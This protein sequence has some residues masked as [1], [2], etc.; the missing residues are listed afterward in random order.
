MV[1]SLKGKLIN[2]ST[3]RLSLA[4]RILVANQ[5]LLASM[6]YMVTAWNPNPTMC[7]QIRGIVRNF[8]WSGNA[9]NARA[10]VKW[11]TLTLPT[12]QGGLGII[13]P[14]AQSEAL[15]A[16]LLVRDL[17]PGD[18]PWKDLL[19]HTANQVKLPV[20]GLGVATLAFGL[21]LRQGGE[22]LRA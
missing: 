16:K 14:K 21:R 2:W 10:Q 12:T 18:E 22:R 15:L 3:C 17:A 11:E 1:T 20:H 5:V 9:S 6:W 13:D 8:I 19:R 7:S 4:G